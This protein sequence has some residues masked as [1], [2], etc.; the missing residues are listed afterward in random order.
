MLGPRFEWA[1]AGVSHG[2]AALDDWL[3][4]NQREHRE[5]EQLPMS[6]GFRLI[7]IDTGGDDLLS[8]A[9]YENYVEEAISALSAVGVR[10]RLQTVG[11]SW[12]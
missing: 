5:R 2:L 3:V 10:S 1:G 12:S 8:M 4:I 9:C 6:P 11:V 7:E